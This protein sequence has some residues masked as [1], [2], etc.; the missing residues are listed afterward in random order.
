LRSSNRCNKRM[1]LSMLLGFGGGSP[2]AQSIGVTLPASH[3]EDFEADES[4]FKRIGLKRVR[5][6]MSAT[7]ARVSPIHHS[8]VTFVWVC[9]CPR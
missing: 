2:L 8:K 9:R 7:Y 6:R 3:I 4:E 1:S 5:F